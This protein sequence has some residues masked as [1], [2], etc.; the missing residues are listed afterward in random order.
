MRDFTPKE[1]KNYKRALSKIYK[2]TGL[3]VFDLLQG[4]T[5][6]PE[7]IK[8]HKQENPIIKKPYKG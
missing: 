8:K 5:I 1:T 4:K 7:M 6:K 3:N 2:P